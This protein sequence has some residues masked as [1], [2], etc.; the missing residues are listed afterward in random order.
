MQAFS[1]DRRE[2][3]IRAAEEEGCTRPE[4]ADLFGVSRSFLQKL[5]RRQEDGDSIGPAPGPKDRPRRWARR[6]YRGAS[7][8]ALPPY[9]P[10]LSP[11]EPCCSTVKQHLRKA[12]ARTVPAL[13]KAVAEALALITADDA[14]GWFQMGGLC[15]H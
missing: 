13:D 12:R 15:V 3:I 9:S 4:I 10:E 6:S 14:R 8:L 11:I 1:R 2:R 5:L 7:L